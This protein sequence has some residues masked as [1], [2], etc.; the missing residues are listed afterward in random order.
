MAESGFGRNVLHV[1]T[2]WV[3]PALIAVIAVPITV[4][5]L[6][7]DRYGVM[8]LVGAVTGYL[9]LLDLGL[10]D[11]IIRFLAT[12]VAQQR[13]RAIRECLRLMLGWFAT[14]GV[15]GAIAV[16]VLTPWLVGSLLKVP[17]SLVGESIVAFRIGG[18]TFAFGMVANVLRLVPEAFL[19]YRL[20]SRLSVILG[21]ISAAGPALGYGLIAV[22]WFGLG[23]SAV[24]CLAWGVF[25][26]WLVHRVPDTGPGFGQQLREFVG[27]ASTTFVNRLWSVIQAQT[28]KLIVGIAGGTAQVAY[29]YIPTVLSSKVTSLLYRMSTVLLPTGSQMEAAGERTLLL[30]L[31]EK[32]SRL[33]FVLNASVTGAVVVFSGPL[34]GYWVGPK[35]ANQ[36]AVALQLL[37]LAAGLNAASM[38]ASQVNLALGRPKVNLS[39]SL[40]NSAINLLTVYSLTKAYGITGTA[41]SGF[42]AA[43]V[44]P[45]FLY[46]THSRVFEVS[47]WLVFKDC[48][49][50][51]SIAVSCV[52]VFAWFALKPLATSLAGT[53]ALVSGTVIAGMLLA[54]I[55][56]AVTAEERAE[57]RAVLHTPRETGAN[58]DESE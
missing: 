43:A 1:T 37:T 27:F 50:R 31:Y 20:Y 44:V 24:G 58:G 19:Q 35:Y 39:F 12:F 2:A 4:H 45:A 30:G 48:Y 40:L 22:M 52:A 56:G 41:L 16:W 18:F 6:G 57:I 8:A 25:T 7:D 9:A 11:G 42:L 10:G 3:I 49:L 51:T 32:S 46:Y 21:A 33:F 15:V 13:G 47:T 23:L 38:T 36:G 14:V 55:L 5:G 17:K 54:A 34:L 29:F 26:M 28:S 53:L